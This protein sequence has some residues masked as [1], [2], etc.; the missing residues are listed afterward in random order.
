MKKLIFIIL[1]FY[2]FGTMSFAQTNEKPKNEKRVTVGPKF[3]VC[4]KGGMSFSTPQKHVVYFP[5]EMYEEGILEQIE[6]SFDSNRIFSEKGD[7]V[8][9]KMPIMLKIYAR[10]IE[11]NIPGDE[12]LK[13]TIIIVPQKKN[14]KIKI[15]ISK[16]GIVLPPEGIYCGFE[17]F[18]T[19]WYVKHG[20]LTMDNLSYQTKN[21]QKNK[22]G[23][24]YI[25]HSPAV[26][27][28]RNKKE[29]KK[30]QN[31]VLGGYAK[32]W[33]NVNE[34]FHSTLIIRLHIRK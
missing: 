17:T 3:P 31:Y 23:P 32:E 2:L 27:T 9:Y 4:M 11:K 20:Y 30:Y 14:Q 19:D 28:N 1:S 7:T 22:T 25:F 34:M 10:N 24:E 29:V 16:Y 13:D 15:D 6:F 26:S 12:L 8:G 21:Y 18:S 5:V 33:K